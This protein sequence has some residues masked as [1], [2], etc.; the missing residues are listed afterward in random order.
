MQLRRVE[1]DP[2][3]DVADEGI[4]GPAVPEPG[5]DVEELA[6]AAIA[7]A[8]L[9]MVVHAEVRRRIGIGGGDEIPA[10]PPAA[11]V[12]EGGEFASE[13]IGLVEG[14]GGSRDEADALRH[15]RE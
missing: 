15:H 14:G 9:H 13:V 1:I 10:G 4:V 7:L 6:S 12:I 3:L 11:D 2:A 5:D 8:M